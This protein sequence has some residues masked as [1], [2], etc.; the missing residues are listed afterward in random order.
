VNAGAPLFQCHT[1]DIRQMLVGIHQHLRLNRSLANGF[2][3]DVADKIPQFLADVHHGSVIE[4]SGFVDP[5]IDP[6]PAMG[7]F[8]YHRMNLLLIWSNYSVISVNYCY[9]CRK[10]DKSKFN[11]IIIVIN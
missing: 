2:V 6:P 10:Y 3:V 5:D 7:D 8:L 1:V 11:L 4:D 9:S